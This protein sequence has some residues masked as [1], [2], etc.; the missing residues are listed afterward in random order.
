MVVNEDARTSDIAEAERLIGRAYHRGRVLQAGR[1]FRFRQQLYGDERVT[2][3][4]YRISSHLELVIDIEHALAIGSVR[5]GTYRVMS[6]GVEAD[7]TGPFLLRP[8]TAISWSDGLDLDLVNLG[9]GA[10]EWGGVGPL[11]AR[12]RLRGGPLGPIDAQHREQW[13]ATVKFA[14]GALRNAALLGNELIRR[15]VTDALLAAAQVCFTLDPGEERT[16]QAGAQPAALRRALRYIDDNAEAPIGLEEIARAARLSPRG[17]QDLFRRVLNDTPTGH[18]RTVRM[19]AARS[20]LTAAD[21]SESS[22]AQ[23]ARKWGFASPARFAG[24]YRA[25]YG[26]TP[27]QTLRR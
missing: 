5:S 25:A 6:N 10:L 24:Y 27:S 18:L 20:D 12:R 14:T 23:I 19:E 16:A 1:P 22:V 2:C 17:L 13:D 11:A 7:P 4:R 3:A 8:G 21:P 9:V 26:E 15:A